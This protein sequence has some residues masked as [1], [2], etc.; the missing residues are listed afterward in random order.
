MKPVSFR[1][2]LVH[3]RTKPGY[4]GIKPVNKLRIKLVNLEYNRFI[5]EI[6]KPV[7]SSMRIKPV[8]LFHEN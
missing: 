8:L 3:F 7:L 4:L 2:K 1:I 6:I 5:P